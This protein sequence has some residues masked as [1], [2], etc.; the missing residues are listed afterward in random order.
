MNATPTA[1]SFKYLAL[2]LLTMGFAMSGARPL[3]RARD[4][5]AAMPAPRA[6][7]P[8]AHALRDDTGIS[9][10]QTTSRNGRTGNLTVP[11]GASEPTVVQVPTSG[12]DPPLLPQIQLR[13]QPNLF[14]RGGRLDPID[15]LV[16]F[17]ASPPTER[18]EKAPAWAAKLRASRI[19][20]EKG[21]Y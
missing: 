13:L 9:R 8:A 2:S 5:V 17:E 4:P 7:T 3:A 14:T 6:L 15:L 10:G 1:R 19:E 21:R 11:N 12:N 20:N 16:D 18:T